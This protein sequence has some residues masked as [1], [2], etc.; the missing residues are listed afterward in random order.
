MWPFSKKFSAN[1]IAQEV[2]PVTARPEVAAKISVETICPGCLEKF[3]PGEICTE[4]PFCAECGSEGA[5]IPVIQFAEYLN[6]KS[7]HDLEEIQKSWSARE[8]LLDQYKSLVA[9]RIEGLLR[10][11]RAL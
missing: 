5:D 8:G 6:S 11:K 9:S 3:P 2:V 10:E 1:A 7:I 4:Y